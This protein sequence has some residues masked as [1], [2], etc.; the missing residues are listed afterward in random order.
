MMN[1]EAM[2]GELI[3]ALRPFAYESLHWGEISKDS[4]LYFH[5]RTQGRGARDREGLL[6]RRGF[7]LRQKA[8][9]DARQDAVNQEGKDNQPQLVNPEYEVAHVD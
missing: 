3:R 2:I 8:A 9:R 5:M 1:Q 6:H 4:K 7:A